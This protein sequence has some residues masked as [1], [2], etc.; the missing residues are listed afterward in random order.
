M[1]IAGRIQFLGLQRVRHDSLTSTPHHIY[2][3]Y[4]NVYIS[5]LLSQYVLLFFSPYCVY[6]SVL[7]FCI[8]IAILL[9]HFSC[10]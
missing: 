10:V 1:E 9:S 5:A 4:G 7:Y 6:M 8:P 3:T 2:F